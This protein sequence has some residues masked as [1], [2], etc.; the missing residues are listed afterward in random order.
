MGKPRRLRPSRVGFPASLEKVS[1]V[2]LQPQASAFASTGI[3]IWGISPGQI[4]C[5]MAA[6]R[7]TSPAGWES[8]PLRSPLPESA[9]RTLAARPSRMVCDYSGCSLWF[10]PTTQTRRSDLGDATTFD[11]YIALPFSSSQWPSAHDASSESLSLDGNRS[12]TEERFSC[13]VVRLW[14]M[15]SL[16]GLQNGGQP[17]RLPSTW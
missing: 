15:I 16:N 3:G 17:Q 14:R 1:L 12:A 5:G 6:R 11:F 13:R 8:A 9:I 10:A 7:Y 4:F 2:P